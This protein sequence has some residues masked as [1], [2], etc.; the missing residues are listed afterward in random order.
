MDRAQYIKAILFLMRSS[1]PADREEYVAFVQ[2]LVAVSANV[3][4]SMLEDQD[5]LAKPLVDQ[6]TR[7]MCQILE[8]AFDIDL[9]LESLSDS[10]GP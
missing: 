6:V 2:A 3:S 10:E 4:N 7:E 9:D 5:E 1:R 8:R